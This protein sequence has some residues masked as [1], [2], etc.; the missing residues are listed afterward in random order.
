[1]ALAVAYNNHTTEDHKSGK[2][3]LPRKHFHTDCDADY[4]SNNGLDIAVHTYKSRPDTFLPYR[5]KEIGY[6]RGT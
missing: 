2:Y 3:L 4:N 6:E 5:D 1:M